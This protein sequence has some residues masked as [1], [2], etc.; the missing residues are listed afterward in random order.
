L[1]I[2]NYEYLNTLRKKVMEKAVL[3]E[4]K[5]GKQKAKEEKRTK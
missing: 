1:I 3:E 2:H 4:I 5:E